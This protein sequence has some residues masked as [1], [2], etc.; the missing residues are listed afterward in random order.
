MKNLL[1]LFFLF[2]TFFGFSQEEKLQED[3]KV[4]LVLSGGGAKGFA[5]V[6]VL[7]ALEEAGVRV[8]Y[9]AGTS[10]GSIVG[11][12][13]AV[14]Y[15]AHELD[16][17][18]R[19]NDFQELIQDKLPRKA[20]SFYQKET[21]D[22]YAITLP[23]NKKKISLPSSISSGQNVYDF[24]SRLTT[25]VQDI[26]DFS[27]L[28]IPF[29]CVATDL[30][31]GEEVVLDHGYLPEAIRASSSFPS[32]FEPVELDGRKLVDGG[33]VDNFP[34]NKLID[35]GVDFIIGV[36][37]QGELHKS[38]ELNSVNEV[39]TQVVG[40]QMYKNLEDQIKLTDLYIK[41]DITMYNNFSFDK[42]LDIVKAGE[43]A[44][45]ENLEEFKILAS[46]QSK[47][48]VQKSIKR[49]KPNE[50]F[51]VKEI[52]IK[53]NKYYTQDY[54]LNKLNL[55]TGNY[56]S[57]EKL[58]EG[59]NELF[60]TK[61]FNSIQ[62]RAIPIVGGIRL[63]FHLVEKKVSTFLQFGAHFDNLYK[64]GV[65]LNLTMKHP[66]FKDDIFS[67][68]LVIGDNIRYYIDYFVDKGF[69]WSLGVNTRFNSFK[70][71]V[72]NNI[73]PEEYRNTS[74]I[75]IPIQYE[76]FTTQLYLQRTY[77]NKFA[78]RI[79]VEDKFLKAYSEEVIE[80]QVGKLYYDKSHYFNLFA[81]ATFDSYDAKS[82][83][84]YGVYFNTDYRVYLLS[85]NYLG[86]FDSFSQLFGQLG[87]AY[88][89]FDKLTLHY[90]ADAGITFGSV[91][92]EILNYHLGGNNENYI[93]TFVSLYGYNMAELNGSGYLKSK[94]TVRYELFKGNFLSATA[95]YARL[96]EDLWNAG[97]IF[98]DAKSGYAIGY[99]MNSI[100]GPI[101]LKYSWSPDRENQN[102]WY[103]NL[104]F[105][106]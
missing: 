26:N 19:V 90:V 58:I 106:F 66:L 42:V 79:G 59:I 6:G 37:V 40:F 57:E 97:S 18:L 73:L 64:T 29:L 75:K 54:C 16:S 36:N 81:K 80:D 35:K 101:E 87:I 44:G 62:Y 30:E 83:P 43:V 98:A 71:N 31:T 10:M 82:F 11:A 45:D 70:D 28:P 32:F 61:N 46:R 13:Y 89:F 17:I 3:V 14:G 50:K 27:L 33:L 15:N 24:L 63:E 104:G 51:Y 49:V 96:G 22:K 102:F 39:L 5:H 20:F 7:K 88:S 77:K 65:L 84:K 94:F 93:N 23:I 55:K 2:I 92:N 72:V 76:D 34:V 74:G 21:Q 86:N 105:W 91:N 12:L 67:A 38:E 25:H 85:D 48:K 47:T 100:V 41:P 1:V 68:D 69:D 56:F 78:L 8:D 4:G 99:G 95:N 52:S 60:A 103:F 53:G 9:I